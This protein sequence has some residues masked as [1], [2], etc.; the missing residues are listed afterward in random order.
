MKEIGKQKLE[1]EK[2]KKKESVAN[3]ANPGAQQ[4]TIPATQQPSLSL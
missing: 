1:K 2:D 4:A 3:W